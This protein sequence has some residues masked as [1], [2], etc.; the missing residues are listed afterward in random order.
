MSASILQVRE[1]SISRSEYLE[2]E[3]A[4]LRG[5]L[6]GKFL[7]CGASEAPSIDQERDGKLHSLLIQGLTPKQISKELRISYHAAWERIR[8]LCKRLGKKPEQFRIAR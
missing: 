5:L 2:H 1:D 7:K 3:N 6:E 4:L 8:V